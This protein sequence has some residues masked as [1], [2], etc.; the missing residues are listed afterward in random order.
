MGAYSCF[1]YNVVTRV[2][3]LTILNVLG[4]SACQD[5]DSVK[6]QNLLVDMP[7]EANCFL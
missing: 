5:G 7:P 6:S 1:K 3:V 2:A 4:R